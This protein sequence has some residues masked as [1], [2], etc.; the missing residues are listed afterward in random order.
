M[1]RLIPLLGALLVA[2][3]CTSTAA[4]TTTSPAPS[5]TPPTTEAPTT[6]TSPG[7]TTST[8]TTEPSTTTTTSLPDDVDPEVAAQLAAQIE[9]LVAVTESI[10]GLPFIKPPQISFLSTSGLEARV[11]ELLDEDLDPDEVAVEAAVL[12]L[13]GLLPDGTDLG[14]LYGDLYAEQVLGFYDGDTGELV[15]RADSAE[16]SATSKVTLVHE[17][18]HALTD[19]HF[20]FNSRFEEAQDGARYDEA[21]AI[22]ALVEG[23]ATY[24]Q[25]VYT[26]Q[27]MSVF[28][29]LQLAAETIDAD[30]AV[31][32]SAPSVLQDQLIFPYDAGYTFV[33]LLVDGGGI[34]AVDAAYLDP[35]TTTYDILHPERYLADRPGR[36][37]AMPA[38]EL[39]D[40]ELYEE[41]TYGEFGILQL[42]TD[43]VDEGTATQLAAGW[44]DDRYRIYRRD[45]DVAFVLLVQSESED[46][47]TELAQALLLLARD[48]MDAGEGADR[49]GGVEFGGSPYA[50]VDRVGDQ[51][52]FVAAT[53]AEAGVELRLL[54]GAGG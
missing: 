22:Q 20:G 42:F 48:Q 19:Q 6:T 46:D 54:I 21:A 16:L 40:W 37:V 8:S 9:E 45:G 10:R 28:E 18:V 53:D 38:A 50:F 13:L 36:T 7:T 23:D 52:V 1:R 35:P 49:A 44:E 11:R 27:E 2:A 29:L 41:S 47:A 12:T 34:A 3:A 43:L 39:E 15:V 5:T 33:E 30:T 31:F 14:S 32:D 17:L 4:T 26:Q 25:F 51:T 24:F